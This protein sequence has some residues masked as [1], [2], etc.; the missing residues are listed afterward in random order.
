M[1]E[2]WTAVGELFG[3][4][5]KSENDVDGSGSSTPRTAAG[6]LVNGEWVEGELAV[7]DDR[8]AWWRP[9][10]RDTVVDFVPG[11]GVVEEV[12]DDRQFPRVVL[13]FRRPTDVLY[14]AVPRDDLD[15]VAT[16]L[17]LPG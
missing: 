4:F 11:D 5:D 14:L 15:L 9:G 3:I 2:L 17:P 8:L 6:L 16:V 12:Q 13:H 10:D 7:A 1:A